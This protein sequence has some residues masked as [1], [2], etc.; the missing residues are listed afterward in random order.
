MVV[1]AGGDGENA[2]DALSTLCKIY[3]Q[4]VLAYV[5][6]HLK[7]GEEAEDLTQSFFAHLLE[8]NLPARADRERGKFRTFL[9]ASL[10]NFLANE[11]KRAHAQRRG[12]A[13]R[14]IADVAL[15]ELP[16]QT[17]GPEQAFEHE[18]AQTVLREA[19]GRL[20]HE[21]ERAGKAPLFS[22]L[23]TFLID[24]PDRQDYETVALT[25]GMRPNTVAVAVHR[26]RARLQEIVRDVL[27]DTTADER[28]V[29]EELNVMRHVL[30]KLRAM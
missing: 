11:R 28:E 24:S 26:M 22:Q 29:D 13:A 6:A 20:E 18:W 14:H 7:S 8:Q 19:I 23:R 10:A 9:L 30:A 2:H 16:G 27:T 4:P 1:D 21:I 12:G 17:L 15:E 3:R 5:R 25:N